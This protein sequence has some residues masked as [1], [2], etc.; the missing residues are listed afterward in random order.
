MSSAVID[1]IL[2]A[3][4]AH[5]VEQAVIEGV[6]GEGADSPA[7]GLLQH[8]FFARFVV[9]H[10][11]T[12]VFQRQ[13]SCRVPDSV[14]SSGCLRRTGLRK[15]GSAGC[16]E[17]RSRKRMPRHPCVLSKEQEVYTRNARTKGDPGNTKICNELDK[18]MRMTGIVERSGKILHGMKS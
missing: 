18:K 15:T 5:V 11:T 2:H 16:S 9:L 6:F 3:L 12:H 14:R 7:D 17:R 1:G 13:D 10:S 8:P 4:T